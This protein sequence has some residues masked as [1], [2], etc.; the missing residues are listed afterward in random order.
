M[1]CSLQT[2]QH[3]EKSLAAYHLPKGANPSLTNPSLTYRDTLFQAADMA[4][5]H[6]W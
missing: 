2:V 1:S 5:K 3:K 6:P 4:G